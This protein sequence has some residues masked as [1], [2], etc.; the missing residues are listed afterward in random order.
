MG[1]WVSG[2]LGRGR[3][4]GKTRIISASAQLSYTSVYARLSLA[5]MR[6]RGGHGDPFGGISSCALD[7]MIISMIIRHFY[8]RHFFIA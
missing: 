5:M 8:E 1:D 6:I 7:F 3:D 2:W 4:D